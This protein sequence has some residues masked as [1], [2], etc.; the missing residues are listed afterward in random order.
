MPELSNVGIAALTSQVSK[1]E[2]K[3][4]VFRMKSFKAPSPDGFQPIF[5][6]HFWDIIGDDIR[7]L[8]RDAFGKG[9]FEECIVETLLILIPKVD[10]PTHLKNFSPISLCNVLFKTIN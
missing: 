4:A 2:V 10:K 5:F 8:V 7:Y 9:Y 6:K 3:K 1:E